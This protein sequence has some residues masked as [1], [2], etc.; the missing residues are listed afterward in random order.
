MARRVMLAACAL[1]F[2]LPAFAALGILVS[3]STT[4]V[5]GMPYWNCVYD[6]QGT[7]VSQLIPLAQGPCPPTINM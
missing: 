1:C 7:R 6:V 3:S 4:T 5:A 2:A